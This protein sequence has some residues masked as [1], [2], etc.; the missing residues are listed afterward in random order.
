[1]CSRQNT[2]TSTTD[3]IMIKLTVDDE[4]ANTHVYRQRGEV[5]PKRCETLSNIES[6]GA[7]KG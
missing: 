3:Y 5:P 1:M 7:L 6:A 2:H 4:A